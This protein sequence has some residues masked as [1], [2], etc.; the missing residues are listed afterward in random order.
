MTSL[1]VTVTSQKRQNHILGYNCSW[2]C[3]TG[4]MLGLFSNTIRST[5]CVTLT[6]TFDLDIV[7]GR[8]LI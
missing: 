8:H 1:D 6:L 5:L 3:R 7:K 4:F 2:N